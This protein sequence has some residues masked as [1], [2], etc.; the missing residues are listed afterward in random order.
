MFKYMRIDCVL[1]KESQ[2]FSPV[3]NTIEQPSQSRPTP[4]RYNKFPLLC[5]WFRCHSKEP[6]MEFTYIL[7]ISLTSTAVLVELD[8]LT[9][10]KSLRRL[11]LPLVVTIC[12][13]SPSF[14]FPVL[15]YESV[16]PAGQ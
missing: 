5:T 11:A 15:S 6:S 16:N 4:F 13:H 2:S 14:N 12:P 9:F 1:E 10:R 8:P 3:I 7:I